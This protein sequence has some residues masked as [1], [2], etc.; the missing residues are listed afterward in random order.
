MQ[1]NAVAHI[2][3]NSVDAID[4]VFDE[5]VINRRLRSSRSV[6]LN[7]CDSSVG[8]SERKVYMNMQDLRFLQRWL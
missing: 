1:G 3:N 2:A 4:E 5:R 6:V 7:P 8:H